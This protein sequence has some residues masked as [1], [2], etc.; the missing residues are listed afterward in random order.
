MTWHD[1][2]FIACSLLLGWYGRDLARRFPRIAPKCS[3]CGM[4]R[5]PGGGRCAECVAFTGAHEDLPDWPRGE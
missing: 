4:K 5:V 3:W 2:A 1:G